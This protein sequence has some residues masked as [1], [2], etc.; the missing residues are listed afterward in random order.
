M[1]DNEELHA[2]AEFDIESV[3][4]VLRDVVLVLVWVAEKWSDNVSDSTLEI[5][6][7]TLLE[8]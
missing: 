8:E 4:D 7:S 2:S 6:A 5:E 1:S 3:C